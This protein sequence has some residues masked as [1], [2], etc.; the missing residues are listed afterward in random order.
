MESLEN[1]N[2]DHM[3]H[4]YQFYANGNTNLAEDVFILHSEVLLTPPSS[5]IR[6]LYLPVTLEGKL[7]RTELHNFS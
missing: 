4:Y 6:N 1:R 7:I 3:M 2:K 5:S